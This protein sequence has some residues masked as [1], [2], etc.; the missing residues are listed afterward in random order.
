MKL[1]KWKDKKK[2]IFFFKFKFFMV[3]LNIFKIIF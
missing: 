1:K 3:N 2:I